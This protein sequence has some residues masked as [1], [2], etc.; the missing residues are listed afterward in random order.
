M[1]AEPLSIEEVREILRTWEG[2]Q[3]EPMSTLSRLCAT[4]EHYAA[5]QA[6]GDDRVYYCERCDR[7]QDNRTGCEADIRDDERKKVEG[8]Q[9]HALQVAV[10]HLVTVGFPTQNCAQ[11]LALVADHFP[12]EIVARWNA[13]RLEGGV[14]Q[15]ADAERGRL[16]ALVGRMRSWIEDTDSHEAQCPQRARFHSSEAY[17]EA[18]AAGESFDCTCERGRLLADLGGQDAAEELRLLRELEAVHNQTTDDAG[19]WT[20]KHRNALIALRHFREVHHG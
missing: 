20:T 6:E 1:S 3:G 8:A 4:V 16:R 5:K 11:F 17:K 15:G 19:S 9:R 14:L 10:E 12:A 13:R 18:L 7:W 2:A